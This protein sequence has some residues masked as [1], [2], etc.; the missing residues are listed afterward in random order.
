MRKI[1]SM[2]R[3]LYRMIFGQSSRNYKT[4]SNKGSKYPSPESN[5]PASNKCW[6]PVTASGERWKTENFSTWTSQKTF[7]LMKQV[8]KLFYEDRQSKTAIDSMNTSFN[9]LMLDF[10]AVVARLG[11]LEKKPKRGRPRKSS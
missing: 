5:P 4:Y 3:P 8:N 7:S 2:L 10:E 9:E 1:K 6:E 11:E